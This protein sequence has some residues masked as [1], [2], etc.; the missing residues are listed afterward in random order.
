[1]KYL[2]LLELYTPPV[3][4][5]GLKCQPDVRPKVKSKVLIKRSDLK[6]KT[7]SMTSSEKDEE[8]D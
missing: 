1:M 7:R 8:M 4:P 5:P 6:V 2:L 3:N